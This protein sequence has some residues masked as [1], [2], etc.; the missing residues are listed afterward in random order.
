MKSLTHLLILFVTFVSSADAAPTVFP[1]QV[2]LVGPESSQ[3]LVVSTQDNSKHVDLTRVSQYSSSD[4]SIVTVTSRGSISPVKEGKAIV[5]VVN[6]L[7]NI[8]IPVTISGIETP[9][10]VSFRNEIQPILTK[11]MCN[12]GG[13]H[14][15]AEGQNGFKLSVFGFDDQFDHEAIAREARGRRL[16]PAAPET[17][18][19]LRKATGSVPHGGGHKFAIGGLWYQRVKRWI[20]EGAMLDPE[21]PEAKVR[22]EVYPPEASMMANSGQQVQVFAVAADGSKQCVT[23]E[24]EFISNAETVA[25]VDR[26]GWVQVDDVPGEAAILVRFMGSVATA[27][28]VLRQDVQVVRPAVNNEV[29]NLAWNRHEALGIQPSELASD[30]A[31]LRR[32]YLDTIGTLPTVTEARNFLASDAPNKRSLIIESLLNRSEYS[33]FWAMKW[34]DILRVDKEVIQP[35]GTIAMTRW[36]KTQFANNIPYDE[37][38]RQIITARGS[39]Q[40]ETPAAMYL[41]HNDAEKLARSMSQV[42]LG[43]RIECAQCHQHPF[44]KWGQADYYSFASFF[45][46]MAKTATTGGASKIIDNAGSNL[47]HPRTGEEM[48]ATGLGATPPDLTSFSSRRAALA[49]WMTSKD[50]PFLARMFVNRLWA[51]YMGRGLVDPID[52]IRETNPASN[53]PLLTYLSQQFVAA[54]YDIKTVTR[55]ILNSRVYQLSSRTNESNLQDEQNF[56]HAVWRPMPAEVLLDAI[57]QATGIA[58]TFNGWPEGYRAIEIWDN[59]MPSYFFK[60]FGKP[61]RV[62]VCECERGNEP[63]IAQAL[64]LMNSSESVEKIRH[65]NGVA[66]RLA[67][68]NLSDDKIIEELYLGTLTRLPSEAEVALMKQVFVEEG[69]TRRTAVEDILWALLNTREFVFN[70]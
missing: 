69:V 30:S 3:Q 64:H 25:S 68:S 24:A 14:G 33:D 4:T 51:H 59:R 16:N 15:K 42:F 61:Q 40:S 49:D 17:S 11:A 29:D 50:N 35:P 32:V 70:H 52:D 47:K 45:T 34:G 41:V 10:P 67:Q 62:S 43:V 46:G 65:K 37:F 36:I 19:L 21:A 54:N 23:R 1:P 9:L 20:S 60:V 66:R 28:V 57:C 5:T 38:V 58:E 56:S 6:D 27:R 39:T 18:L 7:G 22:L 26:D 63:S 8:Q 44:E 55:L 13:C 12:S 2:N 31:F 48:V 53:E